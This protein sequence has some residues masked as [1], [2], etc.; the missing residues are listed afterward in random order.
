MRCCFHQA[1]LCRPGAS[2]PCAGKGRGE[3]SARRPAA[4]RPARKNAIARTMAADQSN[5]LRQAARGLRRPDTMIGG[6]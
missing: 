2:K 5:E 6:R 4:L 3:E 1:A